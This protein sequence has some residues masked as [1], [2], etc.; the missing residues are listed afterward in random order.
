M[1]RVKRGT[2][3]ESLVTRRSD[4]DFSR[5]QLLPQFLGRSRE[6]VLIEGR[7]EDQLA[8]LIQTL[9]KEMLES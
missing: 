2:E 4:E 3:E 8:W 9:K 6:E 7:H 5:R 1:R